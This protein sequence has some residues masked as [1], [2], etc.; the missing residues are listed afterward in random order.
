MGLECVRYPTTFLF[1]VYSVHRGYIKY[2][3]NTCHIQLAHIIKIYLQIST[4]SRSQSHEYI[5]LFLVVFVF[6][7][8]ISNTFRIHR[9]VEVKVKAFDKVVRTGGRFQAKRGRI[10][11]FEC[12]F[13]KNVAVVRALLKSLTAVSPPV[14][15]DAFRL[16][17]PGRRLLLICKLRNGNRMRVIPLPSEDRAQAHPERRPLPDRQMDGYVVFSGVRGD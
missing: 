8:V 4:K 12:R 14:Q 6:A 11:S 3:S 15:F 17:C 13:D 5:N 1:S 7:R 2:S 9:I 10:A 16:F